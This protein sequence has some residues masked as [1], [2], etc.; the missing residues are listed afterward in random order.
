[1]E[2][3]VPVGHSLVG[4]HPS[5]VGAFQGP[6]DLVSFCGDAVRVDEGNGDDRSVR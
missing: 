5:L 2:V 6:F 3:L 1:M 4:H